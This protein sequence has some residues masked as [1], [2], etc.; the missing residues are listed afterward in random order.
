MTTTYSV[1]EAFEKTAHIDRQGYEQIYTASVEG[2]EAFWADKGLAL[3]QEMIFAS[4][5]KKLDW[6]AEDYYIGEL[7]G[8]DIQTN[9]PATNAAIQ[10][11]GKAQGAVPF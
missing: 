4:T 2:N 9:P 11:L 5:G 10:D 8:S 6:Q 3:K 7:S 1:P